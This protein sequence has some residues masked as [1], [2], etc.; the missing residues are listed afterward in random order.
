M[1]KITYLI[2]G[3]TLLLVAFASYKEIDNSCG[4]IERWDIK[5]VTDKDSSKI[6]VNPI[7]SSV[8][9]LINTKV[10]FEKIGN[11]SPRTGNEFN[12][13]SITVYITFYKLE[14]D[15]DIHIVA[16]DLNNKNITMICE[17][18]NPNCPQVKKSPYL[19]NIIEA[20]KIFLSF[21]KTAHSI[22][23]GTYILTGVCF[24]DKLHGQTGLAPNGIELHPLLNIKKIM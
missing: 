13:Y 22:Q 7:Q 21:K 23:E 6:N 12:V 24:Y 16:C 18:P 17:I 10:P 3:I 5:T 4:G 1:K 15:S 2:L 19:K 11:H 8:S 20:R 9:E 14:A